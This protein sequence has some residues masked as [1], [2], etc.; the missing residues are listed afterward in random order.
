VILVRLPDPNR[1]SMDRL[2]RMQ[3]DEEAAL[4]VAGLAQWADALDAEDDR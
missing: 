4:A 1:W 3:D 2:A